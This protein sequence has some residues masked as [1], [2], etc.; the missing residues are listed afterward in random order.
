MALTE[1]TELDQIEVVSE[2]KM[3]QVRNFI[4]IKKDG[5]EISRTYS[6]YVLQPNNDISNE[7]DEVKA[8]CNAVWTDDVKD[9]W[10][11]FQ[12]SSV[13]FGS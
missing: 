11:K 1:T 3:V 5:N 4:I 9:A 6:R 10:T 13:Y 8:I 2:Y 7:P 12:E